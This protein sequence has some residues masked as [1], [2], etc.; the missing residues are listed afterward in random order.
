M[1]P[2][3]P[4]YILHDLGVARSGHGRHLGDFVLFVFVGGDWLRVQH[5]RDG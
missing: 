3:Q 4:F 2:D 5:E 1:V